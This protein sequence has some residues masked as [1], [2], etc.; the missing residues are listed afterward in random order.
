MSWE[1]LGLA[2]LLMLGHC[3]NAVVGY[4]PFQT[5]VVWIGAISKTNHLD[6]GKFYTEP[7]CA[8]VC[9]G[10]NCFS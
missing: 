3:R 9:L 5:G 8:V 10:L 4:M 7:Y 1:H 6:K 2:L